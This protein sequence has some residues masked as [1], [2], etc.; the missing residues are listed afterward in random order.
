[1]VSAAL[2][3]LHHL[4]FLNFRICFKSVNANFDYI[5][6]ILGNLDKRVL[7]KIHIFMSSI[8][9]YEIAWLCNRMKQTAQVWHTQTHTHKSFQCGPT[10]MDFKAP[11]CQSWLAL[12]MGPFW[13]FRIKSWQIA[14]GRGATCYE[15]AFPWCNLWLQITKQRQK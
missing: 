1:M 13:H 15:M 10:C 9:V 7:Q 5:W 3:N 6:I 4:T 8:S 14:L 11:C 12:T 2:S